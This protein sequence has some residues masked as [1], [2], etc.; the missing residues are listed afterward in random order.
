MAH[1]HHA[2]ASQGDLMA[3]ARYWEWER[4]VEHELPRVIAETD[5]RI[6]FQPI[7]RLLA[8]MPVVLGFEA[9]SR[10]PAAPAIPAGVWFRTAREL[11]LS[12]DLELTAI[13]AAIE[14]LG[15]V[16][17]VAF[18]CVNASLDT[19]PD[20]V[21][22]VPETLGERLIID[23]HHSAFP[24]PQRDEPFRLLR[25][26]GARIA[27][28]DVP[29]EGAHV[30]RAV[31]LELRPAFIKVDVLTGLA[32]TPMARL[33]LAE[34]AAWCEEAGIELIAERVEHLED[35]EIL[36][37]IGVRWAQGFCLAPPVTF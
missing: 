4:T 19:V 17:E 32:D 1:P 29:L 36:D 16:S 10:F 5:I 30:L 31:L 25:D 9:L 3:L 21:E 27:V 2:R 11:G 24:R 26:L 22:I 37:K 33:E 13:S 35:L 14:A 23:V 34:C 6:I 7:C 18:L 15:R 20:L 12:R 8:G 28:D